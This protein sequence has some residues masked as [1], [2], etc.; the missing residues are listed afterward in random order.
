MLITNAQ[1][2][3]Y[4]D[5][6][7][8]P[9]GA[10]LILNGLIQAIGT[11]RDLIARYPDVAQL[12]ARGQ[13][14]MPG[15]VNAHTHF[16]GA[17]AR[18]MAIPGD[19]PADFPAILRRLWWKLDKALDPEAVRYSALVTIIDAIKSGTTTLFDHHASPNAIDGSL[20]I[21]AEAVKTAGMRAALCYE[22]SDRDGEERTQAGIAENVRFIKASAADSNVRGLFG[23]H[24]SMTLSD[25]TLRACVDAVPAHTGFHIHVAEHEADQE[26]SLSKYGV[27]VV[28]RLKAHG[29]LSDRTITA[30]CVHIDADEMALLQESGVWI[31]HQARSNMNNAVG[32]LAFDTLAARDMKLCL[33]TDGFF[34]SMWEEWKAA[35]FLHKVIHRDPRRANGAD[36]AAA[37]ARNHQLA[38]Q[39]FGGTFGILEVGARADVIFVDYHPYTPLTP[40]NLAWHIL[41]GLD[42]SAVTTTI[43]GG[44]ILMQD[45]TLL[46]LDERAIADAA[47]EIAPSVW[48][49]YA[50]ISGKDS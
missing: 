6:G 18:G 33:G 4:T 30:H 31:T 25:T 17:Y 24:A 16:Y 35:Y 7:I 5:A 50:L 8:I 19:A 40:G 10:L 41:F 44:R 2:I 39:V 23:L 12:D 13:F 47:R 22:V 27:R 37:A 34:G 1:L 9:D 49:R 38:A 29:I 28:P 43:A 48:A 32:A 14:V 3:T 46:T 42:A 36:V 21:I 45:R 26:D 11:T 20:D 15:N